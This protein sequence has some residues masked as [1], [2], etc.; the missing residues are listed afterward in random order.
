MLRKVVVIGPESTGKSTLCEMLAQHYQTEWCAEFA[1]EWLLT[2]G[3]LYTYD[4]LLTIAKGQVALEEEYVGQVVDSAQLTV[5]RKNA[6]YRP[7]STVNCQLLFLDT[8]MYVMKVWCE[9]VFNDCHHWILNRIAERPYDL[10]LLCKPD[11]PWVKDEL[12]EYPD[13]RPR[14]EL[15]HIY[16]DLLIHQSVPWVEISGGYG[17]R[18]ARAVEAVDGMIVNTSLN[19]RDTERQ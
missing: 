4:D 18:L 19:H 14:Q 12:R 3:T 2:N 9:Y 17:E 16:R 13:E 8:D 1:R 10:Y 5:D 11:L 15:Y 6:D 7:P